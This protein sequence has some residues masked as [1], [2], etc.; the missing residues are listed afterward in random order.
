MGYSRGPARDILYPCRLE[1]KSLTKVLFG[2]EWCTYVFDISPVDIYE[3]G[4]RY[5]DAK[6]ARFVPNLWIMGFVYNF[7]C[8][9]FLAY[10]HEL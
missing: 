5:D 1:R 10:E 9:F 4:G 7:L 8:V 3:V 6:S 2:K